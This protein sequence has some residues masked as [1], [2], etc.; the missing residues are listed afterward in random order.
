MSK[1]A[2]FIN[3]LRIRQ[4]HKNAF[5]FLGFFVLG[6]YGNYNLL[7]NA[8]SVFGAFCMVSSSVY[9][10]ND[11]RDI[12]SDRNHPLK[13]NR[14]LARGTIGVGYALVLAVLLCLSSLFLAS[15]IN[16]AAVI[17]ISLYVLNNLA[18]SYYLKRVPIIDVFQI[19]LG[20]M[21]RIFAGTSG[22]GIYISEWMVITG[23]E[24]S[25]LIGYAKR[26][27][28]LTSGEDAYNQR[29]VLQEYSNET[30]KSF[31]TI[32]ASATIITYSLYTL[33]ARSIEIHGTTNLIY[34]IPLVIFGIFRFLYM[35]MFHQTGDDPAS[36]IFRDKQ[37]IVTIVLW[38]ILYGLIIS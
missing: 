18:Y 1:F 27:S 15:L 6:D 29:K 4:W 3:L 11:F 23:F 32:M 13:K 26:Y 34:T 14:P 20:F 31:M 25:L 22:I 33:S 30:L 9:I 17:I 16:T 37:M 28:E 8:L 10:I 35:I 36:Q 2:E 21:L 5:V 12:A 7:I 38:A 24:I 19:G